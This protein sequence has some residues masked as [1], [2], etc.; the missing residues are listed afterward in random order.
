LILIPKILEQENPEK[1]PEAKES[2]NSLYTIFV[3]QEIRVE[4]WISII[5][6]SIDFIGEKCLVFNENFKNT[7][8]VK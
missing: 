2:K 6:K 7:E 5:Q 1:K 3:D 8:I 4:S